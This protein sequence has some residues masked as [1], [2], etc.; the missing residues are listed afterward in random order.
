MLTR[1]SIRY[2]MYFGVAVLLGIVVLLSISGFQGAI[3]F[4]KVTKSIRA[5]T[6]ELPMIA[7]LNDRVCD[8]RVTFHRLKMH[9][10]T[11]NQV[12]GTF[13]EHCV[14]GPTLKGEFARQIAAVDESI[15]KYAE[16]L[17]SDEAYDPRIADN[18]LEKETVQQLEESLH[19]IRF[20]EAH[21][22]TDWFID[23]AD[24]SLDQELDDLQTNTSKLP[25]FMKQRMYAFA[26]ESR[27]EYRTWI[28]ISALCTLAG[29]CLIVFLAQRFHQWIFKPLQILVD[30]SRLVAS[31]NF[32][33]R[34]HLKSQDEVA[35]LADAM[36][37]M[38][39]RFREI[40]DD[41]DRK[42]QQRTKEI[43]Q[44]ERLAS[45]GFL[46]AGVA[47]EINN[48]L[49]SIAW[50][51]E[52]LE[53]RLPEV[54]D[55]DHPLDP[56]EVASEVD[57]LKK[58]LRRI[59]DEAFRCKGIT[60]SL[61][62]FSRMG[63]CEKHSTDISQLVVGVI[64]MVQHLGKYREKKI[65]FSERSSLVAPINEQ[66]MK[67][68]V[69]NLITNALDSLEPGGSVTVSLKKDHDS[70]V[71]SVKDNGCGMT[72]EVL[73]HLFEPFFTRRRDGSGT[74]LGLSIT[75]QIVADHG[76]QIVASS[77]GPGRGSEFQVILPLIQHDETKERKLQAA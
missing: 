61:L 30:G 32:N 17:E 16:S 46:A 60:D 7:E 74:G 8:L 36:N 63:D 59:Q 54:V 20:H 3:K 37:D 64:D 23:R 66:E 12:G 55:P 42:V 56:Q 49:A 52:S 1:W 53:Y 51:A 9:R 48:P 5:R 77:Q 14:V 33:H 40:R 70:A 45:V 75:Y 68:V 19:K 41:L 22:D 76:G 65:I 47:H 21:L 62:D 26:D 69:L 24:G 13:L 34:I 71:I 10:Q 31:G 50:A 57:V 27:S 18:A 39:T 29:I 44:S 58:Y 15:Q 38:T 73:Q 35:E 43:V 28:I 11:I 25:G 67:Q 6:T 4:R 2:Q 72:D